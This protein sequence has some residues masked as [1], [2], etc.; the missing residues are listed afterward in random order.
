MADWSSLAVIF[1]VATAHTV[2]RA[3]FSCADGGGLS[4]ATSSDLPPPVYNT[5]PGDDALPPPAYDPP[6]FGD[7]VNG[8][9]DDDALPAYDG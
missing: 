5:V 8:I 1:L 9:D 2:R 4:T 6:P 7:D 3:V